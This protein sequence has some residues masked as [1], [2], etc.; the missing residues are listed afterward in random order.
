MAC[1][2]VAVIDEPDPEELLFAGG[3]RRSDSHD[4]IT[5]PLPLFSSGAEKHAVL[6]G[7]ED[8]RPRAQD[9][10][11]KKCEALL[12]EAQEEHLQVQEE[13]PLVQK[14]RLC[15]LLEAARKLKEMT[16]NQEAADLL[17]EAGLEEIRRAAS[18]YEASLK[19]INALP[20]DLKVHSLDKSLHLQWGA[21]LHDTGFLLVMHVDWP[22]DSF[23]VLLRYVALYVSKDTTV[24]WDPEVVNVTA[25]G[26]QSS[27]EAVW[28]TRKVDGM[29]VKL[30]DVTTM[31][32][33][34]LEQE[35]LGGVWVME[36][37]P[38]ENRVNGF[39]MPQPDAGHGRSNDILKYTTM[40]ILQGENDA[41]VLR[42]KLA[43]NINP[44][45][46]S[47]KLMKLLPSWGLRRAIGGPLESGV[48]HTPT[49]ISKQEALLER[50]VRSGPAASFYKSL[51]QHVRQRLKQ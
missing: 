29:G 13:H 33:M 38:A 49:H 21:Q 1:C 14:F 4:A 40:Q 37:S 3:R 25:I 30:D 15:Q 50:T 51:E 47:T 35:P 26:D 18:S 41:F 10:A 17:G 32:W 42:V 7:R 5:A 36:T 12:E 24:G 16:N 28:R 2:C 44:G 19:M 22:C 43:M 20:K 9:E 11:G 23:E 31:H 45:S 46:V 27:T 6:L 34:L 39:T 8:S 48:R